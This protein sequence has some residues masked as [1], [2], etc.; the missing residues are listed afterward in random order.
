MRTIVKS[1]M[2]A[3]MTFGVTHLFAQEWTKAQLEVWQVVE[4]SWTCWKAGD[5]AG[6]LA[7]IHPKYQGWSTEEPVPLSKETLS[8]LYYSMKG[9]LK[10]ESYLLNPARIVVLDDAAVVDYFFRYTVSFTWGDQKKQQEGYG[11]MAKFYV[12]EGGKW[13]LLGDM[14]VHEENVKE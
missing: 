2:V 7:I 14:S 13:M 1:V 6:E 4:E 5:I 9:N 12:R 11:K 3:V 10:L 8:Q